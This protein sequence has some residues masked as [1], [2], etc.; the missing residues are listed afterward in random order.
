[1]NDDGSIPLRCAHGMGIFGMI[2]LY[3]L[4]GLIVFMICAIMFAALRVSR[5]ADEPEKALKEEAMEEHDEQ[6]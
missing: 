6:I 1:M 3:V 2:V 4:I 5:A